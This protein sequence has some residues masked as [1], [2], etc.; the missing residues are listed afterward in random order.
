ML[1]RIQVVCESLDEL[2]DK[3]LG[4]ANA[5]EDVLSDLDSLVASL[6]T[7][8]EGDAH[9]QFGEYFAQW[10]SSSRDLHQALRRLHQVTRT[11]HGNYSAAEA[12][13]L[14]MWDVG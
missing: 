8:W 10:R 1:E 4:S 6:G 2:A 3:F 13:N 12:A 14:S 9:D 5:L 11:A 7:T